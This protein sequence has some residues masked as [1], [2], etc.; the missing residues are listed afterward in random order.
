M[1]KNIVD[2]S[3][4]ISNDEVSKVCNEGRAQGD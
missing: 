2:L 1:Y 4:W 3:L